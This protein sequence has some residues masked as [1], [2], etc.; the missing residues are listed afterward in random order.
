[1][2]KQC[3][4]SLQKDQQWDIIYSFGSKYQSGNWCL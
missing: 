2:S 4:I 1:M 3:N